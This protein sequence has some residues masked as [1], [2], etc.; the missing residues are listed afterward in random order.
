MKRIAHASFLFFLL[1][2]SFTGQ[3]DDL[4]AQD[5]TP[6]DIRKK[7]SE[8]ANIIRSGSGDTSENASESA[9]F[10]IAKYFES[11]ISG[12]S[13]LNQWA[14]NQTIRGKTAEDRFTKISN[15]IKVSTARDIPGIDIVAVV[16]DDKTKTFEAWAVLGKKA[17][18][19]FL[20]DRIRSIDDAYIHRLENPPAGDLPLVRMFSQIMGDLLIREQARQ[21]LLLLLQGEAVTPGETV[22]RTVIGSL[23]SLIAEAFDVGLVFVGDVDDRV[24]SGILKGINDAG[25][26]VRQFNIM[27][28]ARDE[29][30]DLILMVEH[31]TKTR[32]STMKTGNRE[33]T[34]YFAEW[35][36][37]V[38][39]HDPMTQEVLDTFVKRDQSNGSD[40]AQ[41]RERMINKILQ[42][43]ITELTTWVYASIFKPEK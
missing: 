24:K 43:N 10:E 19:A 14:Q 22:L 41:A 20:M 40:E 37:S 7:Y 17:Y 15:T 34:F 11:K 2:D 26:R 35:M 1:I 8:D 21:D 36:L 29:N 28:A 18:A 3:P 12:E 16:Y 42:Q 13:I 9:R 4:F 27:D 6:S 23:D 38:K 39:A 25:I 5:R 32:S 30:N 33:F 31:E